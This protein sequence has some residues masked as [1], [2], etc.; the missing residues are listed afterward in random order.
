MSNVARYKGSKRDW[1]W[2]VVYLPHF[3]KYFGSVNVVFT[4]L[5]KK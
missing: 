1:N 4:V 5:Y 2:G 3:Q